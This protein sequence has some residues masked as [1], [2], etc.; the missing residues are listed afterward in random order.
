MAK[1]PLFITCQYAPCSAVV[2]VKNPYQQK[3]QRFCSHRCNALAM[4]PL[5]RE[6]ASKGGLERARRRRLAI[7]LKAETMTPLAAFQ[8]GYLLG[9]NSKHR[10]IRKHRAQSKAAA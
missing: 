1:V 2:E 6:Q 8:Y 5:K 4:Q 3:R 10:Q 7:R 9:L